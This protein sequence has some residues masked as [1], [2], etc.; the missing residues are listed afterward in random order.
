MVFE[1]V[2]KEVDEEMRLLL[3]NLRE[4]AAAERAAKAVPP[5]RRAR[6]R[7]EARVERARRRRAATVRR[8]RRAAAAAAAR[9]GARVARK[10]RI[11]PRIEQ[12]RASTPSWWSWA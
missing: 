7:R 12:S 5:R 10:E 9:R 1:E 4:M 11:S 6:E 2:R 8:R 3:E